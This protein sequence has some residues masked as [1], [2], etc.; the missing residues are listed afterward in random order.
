MKLI[1][2]ECPNC[3]ATLRIAEGREFIFCEHCGTKV[4]VDK[5]EKVS[6]H[7]DEARL[8]EANVA[9]RIR[10]AELELEL[11]NRKRRF[12]LLI[13]G[14]VL[15]VALLCGFVYLLFFSAEKA[16]VQLLVS[17]LV[18]CIVIVL[19]YYFASKWEK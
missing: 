16:K 7:I 2:L 5:E 18:G 9:E 10:L 6:R 15:S 12:I 11:F 13:I 14:I 1:P 4:Y 8:R 19:L 3:K 17:G